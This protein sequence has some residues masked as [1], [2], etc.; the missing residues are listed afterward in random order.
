MKKIIS[1]ILYLFIGLIAYGQEFNLFP[2]GDTCLVI[3]HRYYFLLYNETHEQAE[4]IAYVLKDEYL[5]RNV[6]RKNDFRVDPL[7]L[8]GSASLKDYKWSGY[9]RGHLIPAADMAFD[10]VAMSESFC[11]SNMSPQV[12][13][14]NQGIWKR[15][16]NQVRKWAVEYDE[17][18]IVTGGVLTDIIDTIG[19]NGVG[20]PGSYY[21][22]ILDIEPEYRVIAFLM[23]NEKSAEPLSSFVVSVDSVEV[24]TG[25][26]FFSSLAD[27]IENALEN[28]IV[29]YPWLH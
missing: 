27:S 16:E 13:G 18:F 25:I 14:F 28:R 1:L 6:K 3:E 12:P 2:D 5:E 24:V 8:S 20:V 9:D 17:L 29:A 22:I 26:D 23:P 10:K 7:V 4:W 15:L 11:M 19:P 21:K